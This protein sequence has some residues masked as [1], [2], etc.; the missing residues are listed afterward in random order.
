M[1]NCRLSRQRLKPRPCQVAKAGVY[2]V[3]NLEP[4]VDKVLEQWL[5]QVLEYR[6]FEV[7]EPQL[8]EWE[9]VD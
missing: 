8:V 1:Y 2:L 4:R 9:L 7:F 3:D 6:L 5:I